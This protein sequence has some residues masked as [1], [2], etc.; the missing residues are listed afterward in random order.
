MRIKT[1]ACGI[2]FIVSDQPG[3]PEPAAAGETLF[4]E[5]S[6][7]DSVF[8]VEQGE[9]DVVQGP[10]DNEVFIGKLSDG[11]VVGEI[12]S[13]LGGRRTATVRAAVDSTVRRMSPDE[14]RTWLD[15]EPTRRDTV[16][17]AARA[18]MDHTRLAI[19]LSRLIGAG[20]PEVVHEV[21][22]HVEWVWIEAGDNLFAQGDESDAA[23]ILMAG[24]MRVTATASSANGATESV[25]DV[26]VGRGELIGELGIIDEAP[27]SATATA[28]RD[29]SLA[30]LS[31]PAF[32][33][34]TSLYPALMLQVARSVL[35][36][37]TSRSRSLPHA[38]AIALGVLSPAATTDFAVTVADEIARFGSTQLVNPALVDR[39]LNQTG[40][41]NAA[42]GSATGEQLADFLHEVDVAH[43]WTVLQSDPSPTSWTRR[44]LRTADRVV[45]VVSAR[46]DQDER[47]RLAEFRAILDQTG[48]VDLWLAQLNPS[49]TTRPSRAADLLALSGASRVIQLIDQD[50]QS[51][52]R[53]A[54]LISGN[55]LGLA[56]GGGGARSLAQVG[57]FKAMHEVGMSIDAIAGTSMGSIM[58]GFMALV[59]DYDTVAR[60]AREWFPPDVKLLDKTLPFTSIFSAR[61][62]AATLESV[63]G[64]T[65]RI[66]DLTIPFACLSTNLTSAGLMTHRQGSLITAMRASLALPGVFPPVI[67]NG[68]LLVDGGVLQ[69]LPV[70]PLMDD[71]AISSIIAVDVAPPGGPKGGDDYGLSLSG[72]DVARSRLGRGPSPTYPALTSVVMN[73]MLVGSAR[74]R[75]EAVASDAIDLY[76][77]LNLKG[78]KLFD[79]GKLNAASERGY[80]ESLAPLTEWVEANPLRRLAR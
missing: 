67:L 48:D 18:R 24:Q 62:I 2:P 7:G 17:S 31:K 16:R 6:S 25:L 57:V 27:R 8:I 33:Q 34:L 14:F 36:R 72:V 66:E 80:S 64:G 46:P 3:M 40:A 41:A 77:S 75:H 21:N 78:V 73:S 76:L 28:I 37:T 74:S 79:L 4:A 42:P 71:P 43:R 23:Y 39:F 61:T 38:G 58:G 60:F 30:R 49:S 15:E 35:Q 10:V 68:D 20:R 44:A 9:F 47:R 53:F 1:V 52:R 26:R 63:Y 56:L 45:L 70:E 12:T 69:N 22:Q 13:L 29:C 55:G 65:T 11:D 19:V 51:T 54:R 32:E 50:E 5:G 59:N